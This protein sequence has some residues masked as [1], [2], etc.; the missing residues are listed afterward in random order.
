M[1]QPSESD[2]KERLSGRRLIDRTA[3]WE[4]GDTLY[5]VT[6]FHESGAVGETFG[7]SDGSSGSAEQRA[8][9]LFKEKSI[10]ADPNTDTVLYKATVWEPEVDSRDSSTPPRTY[11]R[12]TDIEILDRALPQT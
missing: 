9:D 12:L 4:S 5:G 11:G 1:T 10:E 2:V 6:H 3:D 8:R 7:D